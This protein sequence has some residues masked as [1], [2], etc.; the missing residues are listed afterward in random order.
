MF[1]LITT[2]SSD[3]D[4]F[5]V[6]MSSGEVSPHRHNNPNV[7]NSTSKV[8][9]RETFTMSSVA[10]RKL[11]IITLGYDSNEPTFPHGFKRKTPLV[12]PSL[13]YLNLPPNRFNVLATTEVVRFTRPQSEER[14]SPLTQ[15]PSGFSLI[16][17]PARNISG[18][19]RRDSSSNGTIKSDDEPR[20]FHL[21]SS[22]YPMPPPRKQTKAQYRDVFSRK[23][24]S[25]AERLRGLRITPPGSI[26]HPRSFYKID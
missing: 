25:V 23:M 11:N 10:S 17:T 19:G 13:N 1:R 7:L 8:H 22:L 9:I 18:V 26:G 4:V 3:L 15:V 5:Y 21:L 2:K 16:S 6:E 12:P 14:D 20:R 24:G